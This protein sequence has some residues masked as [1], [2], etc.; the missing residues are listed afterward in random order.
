MEQQITV[1][2]VCLNKAKCQYSKSLRKVCYFATLHFEYS[3]PLNC[4]D[5]LEMDL[6][7]DRYKALGKDFKCTGMK[8]LPPL[9][10]LGD[11]QEWK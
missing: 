7:L 9:K 6:C 10:Q 4:F 1:C 2:K 3:L 11:S 5:C 8:L